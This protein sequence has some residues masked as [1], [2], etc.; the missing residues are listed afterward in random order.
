M[1][2][3]GEVSRKLVAVFAADV[4]GYSRLMGTD[5]VGTLKRLTERRAILDRL[6]ADHRGRIANTAGDSVL[7]EFGSAV[8]AVQ[9][10]VA[11]QTALAEANAGLA[12]DRH[13]NFRIG[14]HIGDVMVRAGDL[15]GDGVNIAARLQ[16]IAKPGSVLISGATYDQVRKV[17]P[18]T[19]MDLGVQQMRNIQEPI[20]AYQVVAPGDARETAATRVADTDSPPPM[21]DKPSIAVLPFENMS[22]DPDQEYFADGM[23]EEI[24]TALSRFKWLFVIARNSSFTFKGKAVDVK[25]VGR[26]LGVRYVL[27]GSVRKA[28]GKVRI[29]GQLIDAVT[30]A[31]LWANRFERDLTDVFALQDEVTVAV[32]SAIQP[33]LLQTEIVMAARRRP[34]NL[35]AYDLFLR[36][37][38]QFYRSTREGLAET[39][40]L[41]HRAL[42]LDPRFGLVAALASAA[43]MQNVVW[44]YA[45]DPQFD[46]KEAV[47]LGRLALSIDDDDPDT[48]ALAALTSAFMVGDSESEIEMADRAVAL[49][50]NSFRAW[51]SRG[52]VYRVAGLPEEAVQSFE[53]AI[54]MS[55]IDPLLHRTFTG[56]GFAFIELHRFG[57]AIVAGKKALRQNPSYSLAHR[58]LAA[59]FALLGRDAEARE[60]AARLLELDPAFTIGAFVAR[61]GQSNSKLM[62]EGLRKAG[63][64][65]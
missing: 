26:R 3:L 4:E 16:T 12:P 65:E 6:I 1:S 57:E 31:H 8:D 7:A 34:E 13:V 22:G 48:M 38:Q 49:N 42:E 45:V 23:V 21:P 58:C 44:G 61:G 55:P 17:L 35:T 39:M 32:V 50:P 2:D 40:R 9:C 11:A 30:G 19:F 28:S 41:A 5:E 60:A 64:P 43:H 51:S 14:V 37:M 46:K 62:V 24:I 59:A 33:K 15:F 10:A 52:H 63:L 56:M 29:T 20:R 27:E 18:M 53:R 54:R 36:A 47:R 25:E